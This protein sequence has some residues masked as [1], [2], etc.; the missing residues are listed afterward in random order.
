MPQ[1]N[2]K[3]IKQASD[4]LTEELPKRAYWE[5]EQED[6]TIIFLNKEDQQA[7]LSDINK[8]ENELGLVF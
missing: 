3:P 4:C 6:I 5:E 7:E 1:I 2:I 8:I